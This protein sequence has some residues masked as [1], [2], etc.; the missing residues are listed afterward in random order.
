MPKVTK[1]QAKVAGIIT[2]CV[3]LVVLGISSTLGY[4]NFIAGVKLQG[5]AEYRLTHCDKYSDPKQ[6]TVWLECDDE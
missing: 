1:Q 5:A 4:Q 6:K 2:G 3:A